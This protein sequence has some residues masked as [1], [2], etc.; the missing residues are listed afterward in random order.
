MLKQH[1]EAKQLSTLLKN[2]R[3]KKATGTLKIALQTK[4]ESNQ[5]PYTLVLSNGKICYGGTSIAERDEFIKILAK[6]IN[7]KISSLAIKVA[8]EKSTDSNSV[9]EVLHNL[10]RIRMLTWEK[11]EALVRRQVLSILEYTLPGSGEIEFDSKIECDLC[12]GEDCHAL[13]WSSLKLGLN[14]RQQRW[15]ALAPTIPSAEAIPNLSAQ[16]LSQI[17]DR[18]VRQ[19]L[20]KWVDGKRSL[21]EIAK[22]LDKDPLIVARSY[23]NWVQ[24]G[25]ASFGQI[26]QTITIKSEN[27]PT[28]LS[29]DDSPVVQVTMKRILGDHYNLLLASNGVEA[30][31]L[32]NHNEVSLLLLDLT[33]PDIDGLEMCK[34]LRS[35]P[36]FHNLPIVMV[37]ARDG[38]VNKM[39]GQIAGTNRYLTKPFDGEELLSIVSEFVNCGNS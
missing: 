7:P 26:D 15:K 12:F 32:L 5:K 20:E 8:L 39:K 3:S 23:F 11:I 27:R 28:V 33:M 22:Q 6:K 19:H 36:K 16:P 17:N 34:T 10:V 30:L 4:G 25:W 1:F 18:A 2:L 38:L 14:E 9:T 37:T 35:I 13:E 29:V 21:T 31:N 24:M